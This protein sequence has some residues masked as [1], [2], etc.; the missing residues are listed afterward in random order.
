MML[1]LLLLASV[2]L[3]GAAFGQTDPMGMARIAAANQVGVMEYCQGRG[4]A[5]QAAVDAQRSSL[6][7][8][9]PAADTSGMASAE[10]TGKAGSL[11]NNGTAMPLSAMANQT[12]TTVAALCGKLSDSAKMVAEQRRSMPQMPP[13]MLQG[14]PPGMPSLPNGM[15]MPAMPN[16]MT[17]P[18]MPKAP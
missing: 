1:R 13:G 15:T 14:M 3:P 12:Q 5:D 7:G 17:M 2:M 16:G 9:P 6:S 18:G 4:W 10:A 11:L 8:L